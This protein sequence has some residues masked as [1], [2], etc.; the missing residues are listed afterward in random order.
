MSIE[1]GCLIEIISGRFTGRRGRVT[2]LHIKDVSIDFT[3]PDPDFPKGISLRYSFVKRVTDTH[4]KECL[5]YN[6]KGDLITAESCD[7]QTYIPK[8]HVEFTYAN[9]LEG[10][11]WDVASSVFNMTR[12]QVGFIYANPPKTFNMLK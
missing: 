9:L 4:M 8:K 3:T 6:D 2:D 7:R 11:E 10:K 1:E 5:Y 12:E